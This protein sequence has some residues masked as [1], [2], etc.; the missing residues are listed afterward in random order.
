MFGERVGRW[1][2]GWRDHLLGG[3]SLKWL[4][5]IGMTMTMAMK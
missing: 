1:A 2:D 5:S 3:C 4:A